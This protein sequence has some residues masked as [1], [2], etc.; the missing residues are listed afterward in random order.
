MDLVSSGNRVVVTMLH[1]VR[2]SGAPKILPRC[3]LPLTGRG[4]VDMIITELAVFV[5]D[6]H[7]LLLTE[8]AEGVSV[9]EIRGKTGASFR[10]SK[11][12]RPMQQ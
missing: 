6:E 9:E 11:D 7:G 4:V 8:H 3:S 2:G 10:V 1:T 5:C 12:L